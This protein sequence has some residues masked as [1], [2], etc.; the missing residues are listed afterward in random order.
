MKIYLASSWKNAALVRD[1]KGMLEA[2]GHE[3]DA[4][5]DDTGKRFV[6]IFDQLPDVTNH[7][8]VSVLE[9]PIVQQAFKE[10]KKW[11]DW[12]E[13]VLLILPSGKSAHLEAGYAKGQGKH[14]IIY[15]E[16]YPK[17]E[18]DVMY[19]F[20]DLVS[21]DLV[22]VLD[23]FDQNEVNSPW[24]KEMLW[25]A[26]NEH[27]V[28]IRVSESHPYNWGAELWGKEIGD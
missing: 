16:H 18:F 17:G 1:I 8:A 7:D 22:T 27:G 3:V 12:S 4:F 10:D 25:T 6:F 21:N 15:Q 14:L 26:R 24:K 28:I 5:C 19:G 13:A 11:L 2:M 23:Y 9:F 20:A